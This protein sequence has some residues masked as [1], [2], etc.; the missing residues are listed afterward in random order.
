MHNKIVTFDNSSQ[1][2]YIDGREEESSQPD[3]EE[4]IVTLE[5]KV[6]GWEEPKSLER[7]DTCLKLT[8][9]TFMPWN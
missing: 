8:S 9:K 6:V 2:V 7:W 1:R 5:L 3:E 4:G